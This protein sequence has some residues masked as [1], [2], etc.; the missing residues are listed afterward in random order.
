MPE[1]ETNSHPPE[2][3]AYGPDIIAQVSK[4]GLAI[5]G[6][7]MALLVVE[8]VV[9]ADSPELLAPIVVLNILAAFSATVAHH[10]HSI[11]LRI[12]TTMDDI[13]DKN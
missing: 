5:I 13:L 7:V 4:E 8:G 10:H 12:P 11:N 2:A 9:V 3:N 1:T 6:F